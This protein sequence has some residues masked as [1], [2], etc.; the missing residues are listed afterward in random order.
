MQAIDYLVVGA[1]L[2]GATIAR[3]LRDRG[4]QVLVVDRRREVGGNVHDH[5]HASGIR[6]HTYGPHYFRTN[7]RTIW[8]FVSRFAEFYPYEARVCSDVG[9]R[10]E[11]W[12]LS[13]SAVARLA[14]T[15]WKPE[16]TG[17]PSNF[18]EA[19]LSM[20]PRTVYEMFVKEYSEKQWGVEA[21]RLSSSLARRLTVRRENDERFSSHR[22]QGLPRE[23]YTAFVRNLIAGIP[24]VLDCDYLRDAERFRGAKHVVYTGAID[25]LF[26]WCCGALKYRAQRREHEYLSGTEYAQRCGQVNNPAHASGPHIRTLEWKRMMPP[27]AI[28]VRTGTL[29]TREIPVAPSHPDNF[30]YPFPD[31]ESDDLYARYRQLAATRPDMTICGRLG[32]YRYFDMDQAIGRAIQVARA[33]MNPA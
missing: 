5:M 3:L 33:L 31:A 8:T 21:R 14:G 11:S 17:R 22:F 23:G 9:G 32:E 10:L 13:E 16:F 27:D 19:C 2:T 30:E 28:P 6:V 15:A 7:S 24:V 12:P 1:G 26:G 4:R 25:E 29:I 18:E 20:M